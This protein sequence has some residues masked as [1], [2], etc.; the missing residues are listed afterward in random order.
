MAVK[1]LKDTIYRGHAETGLLKM[2]YENEVR[3]EYMKKKMLFTFIYIFIL[4]NI[5]YM[6][7]YLLPG[8]M[9]PSRTL[10]SLP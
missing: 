4:H 5:I 7:L 3:N 2:N 10:S 1:G 8:A 6:H 9:Y